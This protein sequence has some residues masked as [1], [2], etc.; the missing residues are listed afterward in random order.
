MAS[1]NDFVLEFYKRLIF[2][3]M[4]I[5]QFVQYCDYV[6]KNDMG[7][8]MK[9][10]ASQFLEKDDAGQYKTNA[11]LYVPKDLP[12]PDAGE[13]ELTDAEWLKLYWA[14]NNTFQTMAAKQSSFKYNKKATDFLNKYF[15][16]T[17]KTFSYTN[18]NAAA[19]AKITELYE[20]LK[21]YDDKIKPYLSNFFTDDFS[22]QDLMDG[23]KSKKYN[24][25]LKFRRTMI[26][27]A[28]SLAYDTQLPANS[29]IYSVVHRQLDFRAISNG[30]DTVSPNSAKMG[31]FKLEYSDLLKEL[32]TN[33]KAFEVFQANDSSKI[34]SS[35]NEAKEFLDYGNTDSKSYVPPKRTDELTLPQ[36]IS[37]WW[38]NTYENYL[39]KYVKLRGDRLYFSPSAKNIVKAITKENIKPTDGL[40]KVLASASNITKFLKDKSPTATEHFDWFIKTLN[41]LKN[42][43]PKSFAGALKNGNQMRAIVSELIMSAIRG[44]GKMDEAKTAMEVLSVIKYGYTTSKIMNVFNKSDLTIFS[45]PGLSWNKSSEAVKFITTAM[46]KTIKVAFQAIGY[47]ITIAGNAIR[48]SGSKFKHNKNRTD[49]ARQTLIAER[50]AEHAKINANIKKYKDA[51]QATKDELDALSASGITE[52]TL[53][54]DIKSNSDLLE[55]IQNDMNKIRHEIG[56]AISGLSDDEQAELAQW[57]LQTEDINDT[58]PAPTVSDATVNGYLKNFT[59]QRKL[60]QDV[61]NDIKTKEQKRQELIDKAQAITEYDEMINNAD[62]QLKNWDDEKQKQ[63]DEL[64]AYWDFLE[65]GRNTHTGKMYSWLPRSAEKNQKIFDKRKAEMWKN[66]FKDY[67]ARA[68]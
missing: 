1:A 13:Y 39:D 7:G 22:F 10:W 14:F 56:N 45:D 32:Y 3:S 55:T 52:A 60:Y 28:E 46:D 30:F 19:D 66:Y 25:D 47:G 16:D 38:D 49:S 62:E 65:T 27:I 44:G 34:S 36:R 61:Q 53:N 58:T 33:S 20:L 42:T 35:L 43:M 21:K 54:A 59:D 64:K 18:A 41:G 31:R 5:E 37:K 48:L 24:K 17:G 67:Y 2:R 68:A 50:N 26:N 11:G 8:N 57:L 51:K 40:E 4:P 12:N 6:K 9:N 23:I 15:G 63:Y 29:V